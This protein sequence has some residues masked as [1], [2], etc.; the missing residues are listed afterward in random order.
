MER[1]E[2]AGE[3]GVGREEVAPSSRQPS[4][5]AVEQVANHLGLLTIEESFPQLHYSGFF[6]F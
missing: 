6:A 2:E 3:R 1:R 4:L 5:I